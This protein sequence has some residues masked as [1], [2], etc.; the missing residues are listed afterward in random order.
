MSGGDPF[1]PVGAGCCEPPQ[2]AEQR[3]VVLGDVRHAQRGHPPDAVR[4][5][6]G[7]RAVPDDRQSCG[8]RL[9]GGLA[10]RVVDEGAGRVQQAGHVRHP[11]QRDHA[12]CTGQRAAQPLV[13]TAEHDRQEAVVRQEP[14]GGVQAGAD[15]PGAG[16]QDDGGPPGAEPVEQ[17]VPL[18]RPGS[19]GEVLRGHD[20]TARPRRPAGGLPHL[21]RRV[22]G[23]TQ[24]VVVAG[25]EPLPVDGEVDHQDDAG[26]GQ[27]AAGAEVA[28]Q[29][30]TEVEDGDHHVGSGALGQLPQPVT[31]EP[32]QGRAAGAA[33]WAGAQEEA[34]D[35]G[36]RPGEV[37][38]RPAVEVP[39]GTAQAVRQQREDVDGEGVAT[40][41]PGPAHQLGGDRVVPGAHAR[42][43]HQQTAAVPRGA[44][45]RGP[46][47]H[48]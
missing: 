22:L 7:Y 31:G 4:A 40:A 39:Q 47:G 18:G 14:D 27:Q 38:Y 5:V 36:V 19:L 10:G 34:V 12:R 25:V 33:S 9:D 11:A 2:C 16:G 23:E 35:E 20:G 46:V 28:G 37:A 1:P 6:A 15:A 13:L 45:G 42:A 44:R 17:P 32:G 43:D 48:R 30:G 3:G 29:L 8:E 24:V 21:V 26:H 41:L